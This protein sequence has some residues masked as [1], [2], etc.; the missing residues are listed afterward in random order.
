MTRIGRHG[1]A[2]AWQTLDDKTN[3]VIIVSVMDK[4]IKVAPV[5]KR[6]DSHFLKNGC[7]LYMSLVVSVELRIESELAVE[8]NN[9]VQGA[10]RL[11]VAYTTG[12]HRRMEPWEGNEPGRVPVLRNAIDNSLNIYRRLCK[13]LG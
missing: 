8:R 7:L 12:F 9:E 2:L 10:I 1:R 4:G 11:H 5:V 13:V 6:L 3:T